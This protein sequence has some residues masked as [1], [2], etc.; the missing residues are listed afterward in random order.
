MNFMGQASGRI[1]AWIYAWMRIIFHIA[2]LLHIT[3]RPVG[4]LLP[5][6]ERE[7][8][9]LGVGWGWSTDGGLSR[10]GLAWACS[11][12]LLQA[13]SPLTSWGK[14]VCWIS[15]FT[16]AIGFDIDALIGSKEE[17]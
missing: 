5:E 10:G 2:G 9:M 6:R 7:V 4:L 11:Q 16:S 17:L 3:Q 15:A 1:N 13:G 8:G 14:H 12:P